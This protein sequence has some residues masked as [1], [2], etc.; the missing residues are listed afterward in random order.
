[1]N[2]KID[3]ISWGKIKIGDDEYHDVLVSGNSAQE[4]DY[5]KLQEFFGTSHE[6]GK[7]EVDELFNNNPDIIIIG[8]G[9]AGVV[10]IPSGIEDEADKKGINFRKYKSP[11]AV[12]EFNRAVGE[13]K[14][15]NALIHSTC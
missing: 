5:P 12:K 1:M 6:I 8:T 9:W 11:K 14:R 4:R 15:V 3:K 2:Q 10:K 7:W 13:G